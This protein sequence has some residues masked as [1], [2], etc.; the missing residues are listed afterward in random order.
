MLLPAAARLSAPLA[1]TSA[2][3]FVISA[4]GQTPGSRGSLESEVAGV[5]AENA[6]LREQLRNLEE[7]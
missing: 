7:Q 6:A 5:K 1:L 3:L 4:Q 2:L